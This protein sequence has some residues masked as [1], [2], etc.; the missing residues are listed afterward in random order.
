MR[1]LPLFFLL[2]LGL[3]FSCGTEAP[4]PIPEPVETAYFPPKNTNDWAFTPPSELDW[5]LAKLEELKDFLKT[6]NTRAFLILKDGKIVVEEYWGQT[7]TNSGPFGP[8]SNWY[9]A[10]AGKTLTAFLTGIAQQKGLLDIEDKTSDYL[11][12]G[13]TSMDAEQENLIKIVHQLS[14]T[15]GLDY[16][17]ADIDCTDP[18]CLRYRQ[19]AGT[20]W[21]YHNAPYTLLGSVISQASGMSYEQF[22]DE[23]LEEKIGMSGRWILS[24]YNNVYWSRARDMARFGILIMNKGK[25][26]DAQIMTDSVYYEAMINPS[27]ALNPSYGYLWWL[28]GKEAVIF[29]SLPNEFP[30]SVAP[31]APVDLFAAMGKNG[32]FLGIVPSKDL[33]VVRMGQAPDGSLVPVQ[34]HDEM[35]GLLSEIID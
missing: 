1:L 19:D 4:T 23:E 35:W 20:Q 8:E 7:I 28:N 6:N 15:T 16:E 27:Q 29:P 5:D 32:Q 10:S 22:T 25:W 21:Y 2:S 33:I 26:E 14:M 13:W 11:G 18:G 9:W 12:E 24:G 17:V 30:T 34:F 3:L 31:S